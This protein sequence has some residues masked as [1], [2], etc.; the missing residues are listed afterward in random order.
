MNKKYLVICF[1]LMNI[2]VFSSAHAAGFTG[3]YASSNW[4]T[5]IAGSGVIPVGT[6]SVSI[7]G[8]NNSNGVPVT[9]YTIAARQDGNVIFNWSYSTSD[10]PNFD[11][12]IF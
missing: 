1:Y 4:T 9:S 12:F 2:L 10:G 7:V 11:K 6:T 5:T 3:D 8:N